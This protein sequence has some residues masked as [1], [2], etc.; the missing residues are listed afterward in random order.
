MDTSKNPRKISKIIMHCSATPDS[1]DRC[2]FREINAWHYE[3]GWLD[4]ATGISCGYHY[5]IRRSGVLKKGRPDNSVGAHCYGQNTESLGLCMIGTWHFTTLQY[6]TLLDVGLELL[7]IHK[8]TSQ[9]VFGHY[10]FNDKKSCPEYEIN[11]LRRLLICTQ[12]TRRY[13]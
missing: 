13:W 2:G 1:G 10:E 12:R 8:L 6:D 4:R 7:E 11:L 5:I 3:R 9:Q